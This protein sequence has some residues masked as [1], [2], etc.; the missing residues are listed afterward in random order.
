[1]GEVIK[2]MTHVFTDAINDESC[3]VMSVFKNA[4]RIFDCT[5]ISALVSVSISG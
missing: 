3:N 4:R 1:M 2:P 5:A